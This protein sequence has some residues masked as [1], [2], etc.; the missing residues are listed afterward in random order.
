[1]VWALEKHPHNGDSAIAGL[2]KVSR[3]YALPLPH[4]PAS[5]G[6]GAVLL[7]RDRGENWEDLK[8]DLPPDRVLWVAAD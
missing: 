5:G 2:G 6:K 3:G 7:T 4:Y 1:M 8:L